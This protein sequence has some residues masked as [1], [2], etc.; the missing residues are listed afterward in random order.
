[1]LKPSCSTAS[2]RAPRAAPT[3]VPEPPSSAVPP[4][5]AAATA[6]NIRLLPPALG[7]NDFAILVPSRIPANPERTAVSTKARILIRRTLMPASDAPIMLAPVAMVWAPHRV[8]ERTTCM[9]RMITT[10]QVSSAHCQ[11][12]KIFGTIPSC[13]A[14]SGVLPARVR[15]RPCNRYRVPSVVMND[16][17]IKYCVTRPLKSP[18]TAAMAS[19]MI[20]ASH[21]CIPS[22]LSVTM[23]TGTRANVIPAQRAI[24][25]QRGKKSSPRRDQCSRAEEVR[26]VLDVRHREEL[27]I[28]DPEIDDQHDVDHQHRSE[29]RRVGKE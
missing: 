24:P 7:S 6:V 14:G 22:L 10:V 9:T 16:G 2:N 17:N 18:I 21:N 4:M 29:E 5:T 27:R 3:T 12:P 28:C 25:P 19:P 8:W 26:N 15:L 23:T 20:N 1:M 11:T 13:G